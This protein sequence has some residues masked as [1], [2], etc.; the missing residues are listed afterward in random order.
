MPKLHLPCLLLLFLFE[1][2]RLTNGF[3]R[4]SS[5]HSVGTVVGCHEK[6]KTRR[7]PPARCHASPS[8]FSSSSLLASLPDPRVAPEGD[9]ATTTASSRRPIS[10]LLYRDVRHLHKYA[11]LPVWPAWNGVFIWMIGKLLGFERA[12]QLENI[13]TGRVCPNFFQE[14]DDTSPFLMLVHHCHTFAPIDPLRAFQ[15]LFFPEGM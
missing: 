3:A 12:A 7:A 2:C 1:S 6:P 11:R 4:Q 14:T 9:G 10:S 8:C 15:R 5:C 13:M